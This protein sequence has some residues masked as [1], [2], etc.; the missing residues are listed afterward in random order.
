MARDGIPDDPWGNDYVLFTRRGL[1]LEPTG[2]IVDTNVGV[3]VSGGF[4]QGGS[5]PTQVFDR[6]CIMSLGP[7][8]LPGAGNAVINTS[9]AIPPATTLETAMTSPASSGSSGAS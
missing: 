1:V 7:N 9:R 5:Y 4:L 2:Q 8:G 3:Q 6:A